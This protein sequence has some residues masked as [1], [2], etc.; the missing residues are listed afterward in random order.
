MYRKWKVQCGLDLKLIQAFLRPRLPSYLP[1]EG[2]KCFTS[3]N[4]GEE[5]FKC[6]VL[7]EGNAAPL[8]TWDQVSSVGST[9]GITRNSCHK[10]R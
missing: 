2:V 1:P 8:E 7:L 9:G 4:G 3:V 6:L 10:A 5:I